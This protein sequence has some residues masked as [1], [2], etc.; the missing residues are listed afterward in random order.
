MWGDATRP[1][2]TMPEALKNG[3]QIKEKKDQVE[4]RGGGEVGLLSAAVLFCV[5]V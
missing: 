1:K 3:C 2:E 4:F 5:V